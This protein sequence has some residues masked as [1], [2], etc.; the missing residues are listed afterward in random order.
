MSGKALLNIF[1][2]LGIASGDFAQGSN[3][4]KIN[5]PI[6][7][8]LFHDNIVKEKQLLLG[9]DG[10]MDNEFTI[11]SNLDIAQLAT[12]A[13]NH[14][15]DA[16]RFMIETDS[17]IDA[18]LKSGYLV[19]LANILRHMR[20]GWLKRQ[21]NPSHFAQIFSVYKKL[22]E[23]N[24][25]KKSIIPY[26][27]HFP[28]DIAYTATLPRIFEENPSYNE[29]KDLLLV[30]FA[31]QYPD[32]TFQELSKYPDSKHADSLI[33]AIGRQYPEQLY[34]Y[35]QAGNALSRRIKSIKEDTFV[36]TVV[37]LSEMKSGQ[38]YFP[39]LDNLVK[40]KITIAEL[41]AAKDD[42]LK[43]YRL[44]VKTQMDYARRALNG[45]IAIGFKE[46]TARLQRKGND[47]FVNEINALHESPNA[48]RFKCLQPLTAQEL[49]YLAV[50]SDGLIYTSSYTQ[51]VFPLM[52]SK[53]NNR[54]D[55]LLMSVSFDHYR[56]FI[57]QAA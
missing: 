6:N 55:S 57:R 51:G 17:K 4:P 48:I 31:A 27:E 16:I 20:Q 13:I 10:K 23:V 25:E 52:M 18:R 2:S 35:A 11:E 7:R 12:Q 3:E 54:G 24:T 49:Y 5:I 33:K 26:V 1:I 32:K 37:E 14:Q 44:L 38:I 53:I 22:I 46:L 40:G 21:V 30:K 15:V 9:S 8:Q 56:K 47:E 39:F 50:F 43:Y 19:G 36:K 28:Y 45:D 29:L 34:S 42:R 41:D